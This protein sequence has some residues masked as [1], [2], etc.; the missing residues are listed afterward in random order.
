M[1]S[2][3]ELMLGNWVYN[4]NVQC[5]PMTVTMIEEGHVYLD[6]PGNESDPIDGYADGLAPISLTADILVKNGFKKC[7]IFGYNNHFSYKYYQGTCLEVTALYD[8][9]FSTIFNGNAYKLFFVHQLQNLM[10]VAGIDINF[11]I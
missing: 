7:R 9:E 4:N 1:I 2:T 10:R 5:I 6:F 8:C 11:K 3:K